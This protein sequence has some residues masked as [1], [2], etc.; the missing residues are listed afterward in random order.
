MIGARTRLALLL[1]GLAALYAVFGVVRVVE[2]H[3]VE[4]A[5]R[6]AGSLAPL[7]FVVLAAVLG[8]LLLPG[9]LL[10]AAGGLL[11]GAALGFAV[12]LA[13]AVL[14]ALLALGVGRLAGGRAVE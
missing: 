14:G 13:A 12:S 6:E 7:A 10:S 8:A 1:I 5:V 4:H 9:P 11:F 3:E 2:R